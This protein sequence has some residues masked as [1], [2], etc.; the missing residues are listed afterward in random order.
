MSDAITLSSETVDAYKEL[1]IS[2]KTHGLEMPSLSECFEEADT[3]TANHILFDEYIKRVQRPV[4]K[5]VF[6]ILMN[7][8][9][10]PNLVKCADGNYG[11]K[12][13]LTDQL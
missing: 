5:I 13:K 12:L 3:A 4:P 11:Y 9:Y 8:L 6:Y 10:R 7:E 2:P 1:M